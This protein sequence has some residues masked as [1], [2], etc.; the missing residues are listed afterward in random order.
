MT[1]PTHRPPMDLD[2]VLWRFATGAHLD[3]LIRT[4]AGWL[5]AGTR[6]LTLTGR[7]SR[8]AYRPR[9][10]R[11]AIRHAVALTATAEAVGYLYAPTPTLTATAVCTTAAGTYGTVRAVRTVRTLRHDRLYVRPLA[12]ALAG[13]LGYPTGTGRPDWLTVPL[14]WRTPDYDRPDHGAI[15]VSLPAGFDDTPEVRRGITR[16]VA[17]RLGVGSGD[18]DPTWD[19]T[20]AAPTVRYRLAP[21]P[22]ARVELADVAAAVAAASDAAPILGVGARGRTV[23]VDLDTESPHLALSAGPGAGKSVLLRGLIAQWLH[24]GTQVIYL[25]GKMTSQ[26]WCR[27]LP[28]VTY[29]YTPEAMHRAL[30]EAEAETRRRY[31]VI[32][33]GDPMAEKDPYVGVRMVIAF[34]EQNVGIPQL[35]RYWQGVRGKGDPKRSP[36]L[37]ALDYLLC[38]GRQAR[39]HV[40]SVAQMFTVQAAGGNPAARESYGARLLA[41]ATANAWKMLAPEA[42]PFPAPNKHRGRLYLVLSGEVTEVQSVLWTVAEARDW[43]TSGTPVTVPDTWTTASGLRD[44]SPG[45][46]GGQW[47]N[48]A[49]AARTGVVPLTYAALRQRRVRTRRPFPAAREDGRYRAADLAAWWATESGT[50]AE[51]ADAPG[52]ADAA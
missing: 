52:T 6:A 31:D 20:G 10:Y 16:T 29:C 33:A 45:V 12:R 7:A 4:D 27:D 9:L 44:G 46:T 5:T 40:A 42:A 8:W 50:E 18:L 34:E 43:A 3:G 47:V 51:P 35:I 21:R 11:A 19:M 23:A 48:L 36:A 1:H 13:H 17:G 38:A 22:P 39:V 24:N 41:R 49:E 25:D 2:R 37:D 26:S 15:V 28:G 14:D 30:I 32:L